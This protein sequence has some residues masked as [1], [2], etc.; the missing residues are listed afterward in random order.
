VKCKSSHIHFLSLNI[1]LTSC[2]PAKTKN[3][4][5]SNADKED[6]FISDR[7]PIYTDKL[8]VRL[9]Q[10]CQIFGVCALPMYVYRLFRRR[11][12][13]RGG[14]VVKQKTSL[15]CCIVEC[16][17]CKVMYCTIRCVASNARNRGHFIPMSLSSTIRPRSSYA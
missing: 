6:K 11:A 16:A 15:L 8:V 3:R 7:R 5:R 17:W 12:A 4:R 14:Y 13:M 9:I 2:M 1:V 10:L